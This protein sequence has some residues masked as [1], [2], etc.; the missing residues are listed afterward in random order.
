MNKR[1]SSFVANWL[2]VMFYGLILFYFA[3][4][5]GGNYLPKFKYSDKVLHFGAFVIMGILFF[6]AFGSLNQ[7]ITPWG[8]IFFSLVSSTLFG[9][10]I[11]IN[12]LFIPYR[13]AE[14][15]DIAAD[16]LGSLFGIGAFLI[17]RLKKRSPR[18]A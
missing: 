3:S 14:A 6:R 9:V 17:A 4:I 18:S 8:I 5:P 10:C 13:Q 16:I 7:G 1:Y 2:P 12:Q 15:W 11:E